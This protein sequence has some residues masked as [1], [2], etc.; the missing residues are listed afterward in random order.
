MAASRCRDLDRTDERVLRYLLESG[1]D[2]P[3]LIAGNTGLHVAHVE[4]RLET[5]AETGLVEPVSDEV[6]YRATERGS[7]RYHASDATPVSE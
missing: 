6:V 1:A 2:Y 5:L 4:R 7:E 3:A